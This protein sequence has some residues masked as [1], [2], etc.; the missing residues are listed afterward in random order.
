MPCNVEKFIHVICVPFCIRAPQ[1]VLVNLDAVSKFV[2]A[3]GV[4][5]PGPAEGHGPVDGTKTDEDVWARFRE[6]QSRAYFHPF[7]RRFLFDDERVRRF[8]RRDVRRVGVSLGHWL[9]ND[10][11]LR[12]DVTRCELALFQPDIGVLLLEVTNQQPLELT[13]VEL[14]FDAFRRLYPPYIDSFSND[15]QTVW[16]GGHC[17]LSVV[18]LGGDDGKKI[19]GDRGTYCEA[20]SGDGRESVFKPYVDALLSDRPQDKLQTSPLAEHWKTLLAPF[21]CSGAD[22]TTFRAH[23]LGDDRAPTMSWLAVLDPRLISRGDWVRLC[24]ADD[25]GISTLPYAADFVAQFEREFCYD[26]YWYTG[27]SSSWRLIDND[28]SPSRIVNSGYAFSY[29]GCSKD[30]RF[31]ADERNG[32]H[33]TFRHIYVQLGLIAHFQKAALLSASLRLSELVRRDGSGANILLPNP[34][35]V[36]EFYDHFV[37]FTQSFWFDE[38]SPQEQGRELF[39]MWRE[40]L[41]IQ[42]LYNEVR[43]EIK[44]LVDYTELRAG[45]R[46]NRSILW[47]GGL[48]LILAVLSVAATVFTIPRVGRADVSGLPGIALLLASGACLVIALYFL[49]PRWFKGDFGNK[50]R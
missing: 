32:A 3:S 17:P 38:I 5:T 21:D 10:F 11:S 37:E 19:V 28:D 41:R 34:T 29:V 27:T 18:L 47:L 22:G 14:L 20:E 6:Y 30:L 24:F 49:A 2:M 25:P 35:Q 50:Q 44:D 4:W 46:L 26:R 12:L 45:E 36:R 23:L 1:N 48:G 9:M 13:E 42:P 31:F 15:G 16:K 39:E 40:Q 7:V 33:A 8:H 43:Q